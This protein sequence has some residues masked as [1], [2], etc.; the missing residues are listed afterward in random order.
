[1]LLP[2]TVAGKLPD[3]LG[4]RPVVV[5]GLLLSAAGTVA[6]ALVG[7]QPQDWLLIL[8]LAVRGAGLA[9]ATIA[10]MAGAFQQ[11]PRIEVPDGSTTMRIIQQVGG[12]LG[13]AILAV[14]LAAQLAGHTL[15]TVAAYLSAFHTAFWWAIGFSLLAILPALL[16]PAR[17]H[18]ARSTEPAQSASQRHLQSQSEPVPEASRQRA[19]SDGLAPQPWRSN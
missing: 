4:A 2:R 8:S 19:G 11:V 7:A 14:I 12:S 6:F 18:R 5:F 10:V 1:L 17:G 3:R 13:A 15:V 16:L 9:A